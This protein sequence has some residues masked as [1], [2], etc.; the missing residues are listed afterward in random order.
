MKLHTDIRSMTTHGADGICTAV[1][2]ATA[3]PPHLIVKAVIS[4]P[5]NFYL[6]LVRM[7]L[8]CRVCEALSKPA[9]H[10]Q[11]CLWQNVSFSIKHVAG[12]RTKTGSAPSGAFWAPDLAQLAVQH[13]CVCVLRQPLNQLIYLR[14]VTEFSTGHLPRASDVPLKEVLQ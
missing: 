10:T 6:W 13:D 5:Q 3:K 9:E 7:R 8:P 4:V 12:I 11:H 1:A 14:F 2:A